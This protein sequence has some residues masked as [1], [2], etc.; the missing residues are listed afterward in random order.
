ME[1]YNVVSLLRLAILYI[2][3]RDLSVL[4]RSHKAPLESS[5]TGNKYLLSHRT[6]RKRKARPIS[7]QLMENAVVDATIIGDNNHIEENEA[8]LAFMYEASNEHSQHIHSFKAL[9]ESTILR[10]LI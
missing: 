10:Y 1:L 2:T 6:R 5:R 4:L 8:G 9:R 7:P 3:L